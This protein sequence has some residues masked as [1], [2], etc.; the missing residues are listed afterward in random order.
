V[1]LSLLVACGYYAGSRI[2]FSLTPKAHAIATYW[3]ANAILTA[4]L[5]LI[6]PRRWWAILA[7]VLGAH[8]LVQAHF[9]VPFS[10]AFGWYISNTSEA[11]IGA[12]LLY[13]HNKKRLLFNSVRGT[14]LFL[15]AGVFLPPFVTSFADAAIVVVTRCGMNY[16][17]L[18]MTRLFSNMLAMLTIVPAIVA[19]GSGGVRRIREATWARRLEAL[20]LFATLIPVTIL[21]YGGTDLLRNAFPALVYV[22]LPF[23]IWAALRFGTTALGASVSTLAFIAFHYLAQGRGP[24]A[25]SSMTENVLF[26]Q[27]LLSVVTVPLLLLNAVLSEHRRTAN[28]LLDSRGRLIHAQEEERRRLAREM[29]DDI[30]QQISLVELDLHRLHASI[31][32][33][34]PSSGLR[35][36]LEHLMGQVNAVG[37]ATRNLSHGLHP[38]QLEYLGIVPVLKIYC[39]EIERRTSVRVT[40]REPSKPCEL[41]PDTALCF[42]RIAQEAL[43]N[44]VKHSHAFKVEVELKARRNQV[45]LRVADD[46]IG[47]ASEHDQAAGLG[48]VSMRERMESI[49]GTIKI[50]S[51][52]RKGTVVEAAAPLNH[53][54]HKLKIARPMAT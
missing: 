49:G 5:L 27:L 14:L 52:L 45:V 35:E 37:E 4:S 23:L 54:P 16:W 25:S 51:A 47:F 53:G 11:M 42:F 6:A 34:L 44:V 15:L 41:H 26:L 36:P 20:L 19:F 46:G 48:L 43:H 18:W 9:G 22:P 29:H 31:D 8:L 38:I 33:G 13:R 2:G 7:A 50:I 24:F 1:L 30:G 10:T 32:E 28:K 40:L 3:P 17:I 12:S 39:R 21:V